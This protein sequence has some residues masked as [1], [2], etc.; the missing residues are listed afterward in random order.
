M[1]KLVAPGVTLIYS[2][3]A[4]VHRN[5]R[6]HT[7]LLDF[8]VAADPITNC[9]VYMETILK[10]GHTYKYTYFERFSCVSGERDAIIELLNHDYPGG[11]AAPNGGTLFNFSVR[12]QCI[13]KELIA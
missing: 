9:R 2:S 10:D 4:R 12:R 6:A 8:F 13:R 5:D 7:F 3:P 1:K 11:I